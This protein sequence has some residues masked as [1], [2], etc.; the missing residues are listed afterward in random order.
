MEINLFEVF[1][2]YGAISARFQEWKLRL[3]IE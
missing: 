2:A 3:Q 1:Y